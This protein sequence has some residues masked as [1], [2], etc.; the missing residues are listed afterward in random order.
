VGWVR[1]L[2]Q[3]IR[4]VTQSSVVTDFVHKDA[5]MWPSSARNVNSYRRITYFTDGVHKSV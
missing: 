5:L 2:H 1:H 4:V 3:I